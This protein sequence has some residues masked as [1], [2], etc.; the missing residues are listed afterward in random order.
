MG[1]KEKSK[2]ALSFISNNS[3]LRPFFLVA[4]TTLVLDL[5]RYSLAWLLSIYWGISGDVWQHLW[6]NVLSIIGDDEY[7]LIVY[8]T[9]IISSAVY[10]IIGSISSYLGKFALR[11]T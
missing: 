6:I 4:I 1:N 2:S 7:N 11:K 5:V 10:W 3:F 9:F 8:G